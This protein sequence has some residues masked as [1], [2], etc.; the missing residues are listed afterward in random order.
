ML[1]LC[2]GCTPSSPGAGSVT[3]AEP[4]PEAEPE[5]D[6][7]PTLGVRVPIDTACG[8]LHVGIAGP[9]R[10]ADPQLDALR[11]A[12]IPGPTDG[13]PVAVRDATPPFVV[14]GHD[15]LQAQIAGGPRPEVSCYAPR[16]T[17][18]TS[19]DSIVCE[20][21]GGAQALVH[22]IR[23][24]ERPS[25]PAQ[26]AALVGTLDG[27]TAVFASDEELARCAVGLPPAIA[28]TASLGP[29]PDDEGRVVRIVE[30]LDP[31]AGLTMLVTVSITERDEFVQIEHHE[32]W[33]TDRGPGPSKPIAAAKPGHPLWPTPFEGQ[34]P[35]VAFTELTPA[36]SSGDMLERVAVGRGDLLPR[37]PSHVVMLRH[38]VELP[39]LRLAA[40]LDHSGGCMMGWSHSHCFVTATDTYCAGKGDGELRRLVRDFDLQPRD[41]PAHAW[42]ELGVVLAGT[43]Q[44]VL[45]P[46]GMGA[47]TTVAGALAHGPVVQIDDQRVVLRFTGITE[48]PH[49]GVAHTVEITATGAVD[50]DQQTRWA[51]EQRGAEPWP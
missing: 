41:L 48:R 19:G 32:L 14:R 51:R 49:Q 25:T 13:H 12:W 45:D 2:L 16:G 26:W 34:C 27:A 36:L 39:G 5:I 38:H 29:R 28:A 30:R 40:V 37:P 6:A 4:S 18:A 35:R 42:L 20:G 7:P 33:T 47:C 9:W 50:S 46:I 22:Q 17:R 8:G 31:S 1:A 43:E 11:E 23:P 15:F 24:T 21:Q 44:L 10:H 3:T